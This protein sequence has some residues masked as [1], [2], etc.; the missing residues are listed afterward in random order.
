VR[1]GLDAD[2]AAAWLAEQH[3]LARSGGFAATLHRCVLAWADGPH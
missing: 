3:A 2:E 1:A